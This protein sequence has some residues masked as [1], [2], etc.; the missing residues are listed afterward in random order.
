MSGN[1]KRIL[2]V[3]G[4]YVGLVTALRLQKLLR[5]QL[6]R[7]EVEIVVVDPRSFMTYQP[8]LPEASAGSLE[9]RHVVVPLRRVL[10]KC[11]VRTARVTRI[12]HA[13]R[14]A[15]LAPHVGDPYDLR[16]DEL[17][18][19]VG[20]VPRT[21]PIPGLA[22]FGIGFK[23]IE[24]A[25][26]LRN[27]V[28][29][30]LDEADALP[31][32]DPRFRELRARLLTFVFVGGGFAG[33]E[34][35]AE[36]E[37]MARDACRLYN[38]VKREDM[39]WVLVE[40]AGKII[41]EFGEELSDYTRQRLEERGIEVKLNTR[42]ESCVNGHIVLSDGTEFDADTLVWTAGVK[43]NPML[44]DTDLPL[45]P[46]GHVV[47]LPT[48]QVKDTPH[49]W[50]AGDC[51]QVPD[52]AKGPG[53]YCPP[54]AQHGVR[55]AKHLARNIQRV[56]QGKPP[57][58]FKHKNKGAVAGLG[59]HKGVA[60]LLG[61]IHLKGW[62]AW[63]VHRTYHLYAVPTLNRKVRTV[64]DWTLALFFRREIVSLGTLHS[65][66]EEFAEVAAESTPQ[67]EAASRPPGQPVPKA[68]AP[69]AG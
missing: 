26:G 58:P 3:G 17:V 8:F 24:E 12:D 60:N 31:Y 13:R 44:R 38:E 34:A 25:I 68:G 16:Y 45:G 9:P 56:M 5:R 37:D 14:I 53:A 2:I 22:E 42:L 46:K 48:L 52:L 54:T 51:A 47:C 11:D 63:F 62:P 4:G 43:P 50:A 55:Q 39:R 32:S 65:P 21:L 10:D 57:T 64:V 19:G 1:R 15:T 67:P 49:A 66:R 61:W 20:A 29:D 41:P 6:K 28:L 40:A 35:L 59:L 7:G 23:T 30:K 27:R 36:L 33:V 18:V 69:K